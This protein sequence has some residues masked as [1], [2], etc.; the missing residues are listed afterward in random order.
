LS[1]VLLFDGKLIVYDFKS[2]E[3][4]LVHH[5]SATRKN[6][7]TSDFCSQPD[8][9][10]KSWGWAIAHQLAHGLRS[11]PFLKRVSKRRERLLIK[12]EKTLISIFWSRDHVFEERA[13][14]PKQLSN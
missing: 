9:S 5:V 3:F 13:R 6:R 14:V 12:E 2:I 11:I 10:G 8:N 4:L 1:N 7:K